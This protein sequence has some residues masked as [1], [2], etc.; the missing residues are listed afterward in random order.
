MKRITDGPTWSRAD[1]SVAFQHACQSDGSTARIFLAATLMVLVSILLTG[2]GTAQLR[3]GKRPDINALNTSLQV[4]KSTQPA[5]QTALG[6][7]DGRGRSMLPWQNSPRT[8]WTYYYEEGVIDL[9]GA[10]SDDRRIFLF[11]FFDGDI[12]DGYMWFSSLKP[13]N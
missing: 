7:P 13:P 4:G 9:G 5:V 1:E 6:I 12:F 3:V 2:C 10:N 11:V 8:V